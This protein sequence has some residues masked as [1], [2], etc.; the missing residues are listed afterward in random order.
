[1]ARYCAEGVLG[2]SMQQQAYLASVNDAMFVPAIIVLMI[3][4]LGI[5]LNK[6]AV[7]NENIQQHSRLIPASVKAP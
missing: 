2:S 6:K 5:F 7:E 3:V 4:P 1:M